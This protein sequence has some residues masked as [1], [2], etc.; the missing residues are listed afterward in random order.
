M[1]LPS[2]ILELRDRDNRDRT[3]QAIRTR[4]LVILG[5]WTFVLATYL[6]CGMT[7]YLV[8]I[9]IIVGLTLLVNTIFYYLIRKWQFP[10]VIAIGL[11]ADAQNPALVLLSANLPGTSDAPITATELGLNTL[12]N[13]LSLPLF[14]RYLR[15]FEA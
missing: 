15:V 11:P 13:V 2:F 7:F 14:K 6:L 8:P 3:L 1:T 4:Y 5:I 9:H 10:L 12:S